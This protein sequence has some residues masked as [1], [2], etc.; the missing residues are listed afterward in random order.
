[1]ISFL[2]MFRFFSVIYMSFSFLLEFFVFILFSWRKLFFV[3]SLFLSFS[4]FEM[5]IRF[6]YLKNL[7][8]VIFIIYI[9]YMW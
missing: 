5:K 2:L 4:F 9:M 7:L 6:L 3:I 8:Y 1:M